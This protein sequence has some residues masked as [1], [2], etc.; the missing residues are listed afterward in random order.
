MGRHLEMRCVSIAVPDP[1]HS[2]LLFLS[3]V[4]TGTATQTRHISRWQPT[5]NS[6]IKTIAWREL[7]TENYQI[8]AADVETS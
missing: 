6:M 2:L 5:G 7:N 3:R 8:L 4:E 1:T